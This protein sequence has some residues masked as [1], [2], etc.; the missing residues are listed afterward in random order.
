[1]SDAQNKGPGVAFWMTVTMAVLLV[2]YPLSIGPVAWL[3]DREMLPE[4]VAEPLGI[5]YLPLQYVV[6]SSPATMHLY[7]WYVSLWMRD[8]YPV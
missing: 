6:A 3:V 8:P 4:A 7:A 1:M 5:V 2:V